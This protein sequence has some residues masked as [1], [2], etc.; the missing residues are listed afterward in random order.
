MW[1]V[2]EEIPVSF[3]APMVMEVERI[4]SNNSTLLLSTSYDHVISKLLDPA[5]VFGGVRHYKT[6]E[7]SELIGSLGFHI[8]DCATRG[9]LFS[10]ISNFLVFFY[11]HALHR[12]EDRVKR[13]FDKKS[14][15]EFFQKGKGIVYIF[16]AAEKKK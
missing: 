15:N 6:K 3:E 11:K 14:K 5:Y 7:L 4:L 13:F 2:F 12:K 16:I 9:Y 10:L 8:N 1:E